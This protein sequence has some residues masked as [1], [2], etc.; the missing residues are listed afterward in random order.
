[1][2]ATTSGRTDI[3]G[4]HDSAAGAFCAVPAE[5]GQQVTADAGQVMVPGQRRFGGQPVGDLPAARPG[6]AGPLAARPGSPACS[7]RSA[8]LPATAPNSPGQWLRRPPGTPRPCSAGSAA[9]ATT[10]TVSGRDNRPR[11][12]SPSP[13]PPS[14]PG[15]DDLPRPRF[16]SQVSQRKST[17]RPAGCSRSC[18][19]RPNGAESGRC[20]RRHRKGPGCTSAC[21]HAR[22]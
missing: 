22:R 4:R 19:R 10:G 18:R 12:G 20:E 7:A 17:A 16:A 21:L 14:A 11:K 1:M 2:F 8:G 5:P 6:R 3:P 9:S 13:A 15:Q